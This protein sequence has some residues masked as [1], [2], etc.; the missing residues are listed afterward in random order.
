MHCATGATTELSL[1]LKKSFQNELQKFLYKNVYEIQR[2]CPSAPLWWD[3]LWVLCPAL[4]PPAQHRPGQERPWPRL[5]REAVAA[6]S[7]TGFKVGLDGALSTLLWWKGSL[8]MARGW[9]CV[10]CKVP[11]NPNLQRFCILFF[12]KA[13]GLLRAVQPCCH[14]QVHMSTTKS[15]VGWADNFLHI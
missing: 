3:P 9:D 5:P 13:A 8:P 4:E 7:L 6:P 11:S 2:F 1:F 15:A 14:L 12:C 10:I